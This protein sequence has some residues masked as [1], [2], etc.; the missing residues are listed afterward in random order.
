MRGARDKEMRSVQVA[1]LADQQKLLRRLARLREAQLDVQ[2]DEDCDNR[3]ASIPE[4]EQLPVD[5]AAPSLA[6]LLL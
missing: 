4:G 2:Y 3:W 5:R 6:H 1:H